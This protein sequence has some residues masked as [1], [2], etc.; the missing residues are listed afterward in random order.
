MSEGRET[1][2]IDVNEIMLGFYALGNT[3][4]GFQNANEAQKQ[5]DIRKKQVDEKTYDIQSKRAK[6]MAD[7]VKKWAKK[8]GYKGN[9]IKAWWTARPNVLSKAIGADVDSSKNPTD[10]L[11]QFADG[12][13]LGVSAKSTK[14]SSEIGFKNPGLGR[15]DKDLGLDNTS[16]RS[17]IENNTIAEL[18]LPKNQKARKKYIRNNEEIKKRTNK[19]GL[20]IIEKIRDNTLNK[21]KSMNQEELRKYILGSWMDAGSEMYPRYIKVTGRYGDK[22]PVKAD[23]VDPLSNPKLKALLSNTIKLEP[24]GVASIGVS[25]GGKKLMRARVKWESEKLASSMD[26]SVEGW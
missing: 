24:L 12:N 17:G 2:G 10:T 6:V 21:M 25:A 4:S 1:P 14:G 26:F 15:I 23:I 3:W 19:I 8:N 22:K 16:I 9:V 20:E 13:F 11:L 18:G 5:L 7:E